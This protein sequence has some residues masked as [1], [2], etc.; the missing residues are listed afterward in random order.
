MSIRPRAL[1]QVRNVTPPPLPA[2]TPVPPRS[3]QER[4]AC[5]AARR[6]LVRWFGDNAADASVPGDN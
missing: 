2:L 6:A 4:R 5:D 3:L 1:R